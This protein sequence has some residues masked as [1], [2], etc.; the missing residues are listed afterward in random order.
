MKTPEKKI[1]DH[2]REAYDLPAPVRRRYARILM[3]R[4]VYWFLKCAFSSSDVNQDLLT[5]DNGKT[6]PQLEEYE[7]ELKRE[8]NK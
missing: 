1:I 4:A 5:H 7:S 8:K 6:F 3:H 2:L